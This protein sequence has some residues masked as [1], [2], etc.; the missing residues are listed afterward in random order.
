MVKTSGGSKGIFD[1]L[2]LSQPSQSRQTVA[3]N[4]TDDLLHTITK[5]TIV[6]AQHSQKD[7]S[8]AFTVT[9]I[10]KID[11]ANILKIQ[12]TTQVCARYQLVCVH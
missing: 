7:T 6:K 2:G 11:P 3:V 5:S 9:G 10:G 1:R 12:P 4:V 8:I